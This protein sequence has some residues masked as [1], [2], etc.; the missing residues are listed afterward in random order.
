MGETTGAAGPIT[1]TAVRLVATVDVYGYD[2]DRSKRQFT[3]L[4]D[5]TR[6]VEVLSAEDAA[7]DAKVQTVWVPRVVPGG[8]A[9]DHEAVAGEGS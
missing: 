2:H 1:E 4:A 9:E 6:A 5:A 7:E 8:R 3:K